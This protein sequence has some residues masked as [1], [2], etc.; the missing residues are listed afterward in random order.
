MRKHDLY[1]LWFLVPITLQTTGSCISRLS[2][3]HAHYCHEVCQSLCKS[4]DPGVAWSC[5]RADG[6][7][8]VPIGPLCETCWDL[9]GAVGY[10]PPDC[11]SFIGDYHKKKKVRDNVETARQNRARSAS[12][13]EASSHSGATKVCS[14][15]FEIQRA[16]M[17]V[18][19]RTEQDLRKELNRARM[20]KSALVALRSMELPKFSAPNETEVYYCFE[21]DPDWKG[22]RGQIEVAKQTRR[23][24]KKLGR[25]LFT[26]HAAQSMAK[27]VDD[28]AGD[29]GNASADIYAG[30]VMNWQ[31]FTSQWN[32]PVSKEDEDDEEME[33]RASAPSAS[34]LEGK[35]AVMFRAGSTSLPAADKRVTTPIKRAKSVDFLLDSPRSD[36]ASDGATAT[37]QAPSKTGTSVASADAT[38]CASGELT[39]FMSEGLYAMYR[40]NV[41]NICL[42]LA[43]CELVPP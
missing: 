9:G 29:A 2:E 1:M 36:A 31:K 19:L 35:G 39:D 7:D 11:Q 26:G 24:V 14:D 22:L 17:D 3:T 16:I 38:S 23:V 30:V 8:N 37:S 25:E 12:S 27:V 13:Q 41:L 20:P 15:T 34:A 6:S 4:Q 33:K 21:P 42:I 18:D 32:K 43:G 28:M 40:D 10:E 5:Y